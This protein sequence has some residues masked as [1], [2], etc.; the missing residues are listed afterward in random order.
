[1]KATAGVK[2]DFRNQKDDAQD[3][4]DYGINGSLEKQLLNQRLLIGLNLEYSKWDF[5]H[6]GEKNL[7]KMTVNA[8]YRI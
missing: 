1:M 6:S 8:G 4:S 7:Y 3:R 2:Y 5:V